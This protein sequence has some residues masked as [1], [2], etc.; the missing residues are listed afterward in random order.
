FALMFVYLA[1]RYPNRRRA[2]AGYFEAA[3][4]DLV[5]LCLAVVLVVGLAVKDGRANRTSWAL[6]EVVITG[7]WLTFAIPLVT[8]ASSIE[9]RSRGRIPWVLPS[10]GIAGAMFGLFFLYYFYA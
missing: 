5:F 3:G 8:V 4:I 7:Y 10:I 6:Y 2:F 1:L 9:S